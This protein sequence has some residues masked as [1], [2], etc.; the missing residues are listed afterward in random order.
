MIFSSHDV[1]TKSCRPV[2]DLDDRRS[3]RTPGPFFSNRPISSS[4]PLVRGAPHCTYAHAVRPISRKFGL[5]GVLAESFSGGSGLR[6]GCR[7][8]LEEIGWMG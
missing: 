4:G 6:R 7:I 8:L 3:P 5:S 2:H 1:R